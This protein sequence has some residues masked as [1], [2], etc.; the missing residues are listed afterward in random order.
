M[1]PG[2]TKIT[3]DTNHVMGS[4]FNRILLTNLRVFS[5]GLDLT[6]ISFTNTN[7]HLQA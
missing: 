2:E 3:Q 6:K 7:G 4:L 5:L 1:E